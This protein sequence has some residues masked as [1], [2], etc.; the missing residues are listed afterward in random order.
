MTH[1]ELIKILQE[2]CSETNQIPVKFANY[3]A[4]CDDD[5]AVYYNTRTKVIFIAEQELDLEEFPNLEEL[6]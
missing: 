2:Q 5:I 6:K 4:G 1:L 3:N